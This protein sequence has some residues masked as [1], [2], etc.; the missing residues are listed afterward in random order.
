M[1]IQKWNCWSRLSET[2]KYFLIDHIDRIRPIG[3]YDNEDRTRLVL[4]GYGLIYMHPKESIR[5][6][7]TALTERGRDIVCYILG[8]YA[9]ALTR[10]GMSIEKRL[11]PS[12]TDLLNR[13]RAFL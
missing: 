10:C 5:P 9:D 6:I 12:P 7:G 4:I 8:M 3:H 11:L 2:Q 1:A 13:H